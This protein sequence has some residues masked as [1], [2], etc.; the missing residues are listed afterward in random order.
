MYEIFVDNQVIHSDITPLESCK[1]LEPKLTM[2]DNSAGSLEF[3]V[4]PGNQGY[5]LINKLTSTIVVTEDGN[6]LWRGRCIQ[7]T[8]DFWNNKKYLIEGG[9]AILNDSIQPPREFNVNN[10]TV[11]TFLEAL[12]ATHNQQMLGNTSKLFKVGIVT[13]DDGD[14]LAD[15]ASIHRYTNYES[16]LECINAKLIDRLGGHIRVRWALDDDSGTYKYIIDYLKDYLTDATDQVIQFGHN[17]LDF[18]KSFNV[19]DLVTA[20]IPRG[21]R[22]EESPI[23]ALEAYT[24]VANAATDGTW[25]TNGS[26]FVT[27]SDAIANY[28]FVCGVVD[29]SGVTDPSNLLTKAKK[30]LQSVQFNK[31]S[32]EVSLVDLHYLNPEIESL[33]MLEQVHCISDPHGMDTFFPVT[34]MEI[35][36]LDPSNTVYRLGTEINTSLT[37]AS[38]KISSELLRYIDSTPSESALMNSAKDNAR[39]M[40]EGTA[41]GGFASFMYGIDENGNAVVDPDDHTVHEDRATGIRVAN[42]RYDT[43]ATRRWVFTSG[44]LMHQTKDTSTNSW[45]T[46]NI[47]LTMDGGVVADRIQVGCI[48]LFGN[49]QNIN[50]NSPSYVPTDHNAFLQ[51]YN[52]NNMIGRWGAEGIWINKGQLQLGTYTSGSYG[53]YK[54]ASGVSNAAHYPAIINDDG[55]AFFRYATMTQGCKVGCAT[56]D[57]Q[58]VLGN[59]GTTAQMAGMRIGDGTFG[60]SVPSHYSSSSWGGIAFG[61]EAYNKA[62]WG[63]TSCILW[64]ANETNGGWSQGGFFV[65]RGAPNESRVNYTKQV[66]NAFMI[67]SGGSTAAIFDEEFYDKVEWLWDHRD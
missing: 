42:A 59:F 46:P 33:K 31:M 30:Y 14:A 26:I 8:T 16:T 39:A 24:T 37:S 54:N 57:A 36:L 60:I 45:K 5:N 50:P 7:E 4:P 17:L 13:V 63:N 48:K 44:G 41:D 49:A 52:G 29:W 21:E 25:H 18:T 15:D 62:G 43:E 23:E 2:E 6:E 27:N 53:S 47:A 12:I 55:S 67:V 9:L 11:R 40:I 35:D 32:L 20:I 22:L 19:T 10:T 38:S 65:V 1:I 34:K 56:I 64:D 66:Y 28:G 61:Y 58:G 3:T 51:V